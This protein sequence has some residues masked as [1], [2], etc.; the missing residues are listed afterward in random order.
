MQI[1]AKASYRNHMSW[2]LRPVDANYAPDYYRIITKPVDVTTIG[3][4]VKLGHYP[5]VKSMYDDIKQMWTNCYLYN[6]ADS[7]VRAAGE[8][9]ELVID[10]EW[11]KQNYDSK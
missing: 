10:A 7:P 3:N 2:F 4:R 8:A 1:S 5:N 9:M 6:G 11:K